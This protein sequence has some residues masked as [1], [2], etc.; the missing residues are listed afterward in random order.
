[1]KSKTHNTNRIFED[2]NKSIEQLA[3]QYS[4]AR[5]I[6][7]NDLGI[8]KD[9]KEDKC[10]SLYMG[11]MN[12]SAFKNVPLSD[13]FKRVTAYSLDYTNAIKALNGQEIDEKEINDMD[14]F[15][16]ALNI[17]K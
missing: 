11:K 10:L 3:A 2:L 8:K 9:S 12:L 7:Y 6:S 1:M 5:E 14:L 16:E 13:A 4:K 17:C 15:N